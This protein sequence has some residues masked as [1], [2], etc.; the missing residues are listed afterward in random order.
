MKQDVYLLRDHLNSHGFDA[1]PVDDFTFPEIRSNWIDFGENL[2]KSHKTFIFIVSPLLYN[3]CHQG[4]Y[5]DKAKFESL[6]KKTKGQYIPLVLLRNLDIIYYRDVWKPRV[7][8][9]QLSRN[10]VKEAHNSNP[11]TSM[12]QEKDILSKKFIDDHVILH[13]AKVFNLPVDKLQTRLPSES[14]ISEHLSLYLKS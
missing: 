3:L 2:A 5:G 13:D 1:Q 8:L 14:D 9:V 6:I 12:N 7:F 4:K 10:P 11:V